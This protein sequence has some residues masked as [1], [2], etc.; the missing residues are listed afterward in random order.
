MAAITDFAQKGFQRLLLVEGDEDSRFLFALCQYLKLDKQIWIHQVEGLPKLLQELTALILSAEFSRLHSIGIV[1]DADF[2]TN[3]FQS[4][5]SALQRANRESIR[6]QYHI[7]TQAQSVEGTK[8]RVGIFILPDANVEGMLEDL[9]LQAYQADPIVDCVEQYFACLEKQNSL[10]TNLIAKAKMRTLIAG[11]T[12]SSDQ[13]DTV[14]DLQYVY[15][16]S[17]WSWEKPRFDDIKHFL[18]VIVAE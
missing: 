15:R 18:Q 11:K 17:W 10:R 6:N 16:Q 1:R 3:A 9:V 5:C 8:P 2:K 14:W 13:G 7:P 4:V 12:A